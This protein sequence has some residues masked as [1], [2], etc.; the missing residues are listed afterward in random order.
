MYDGGKIII[1]LIIFVVL[2]SI[3][4]WYNA[5]TGSTDYVPDLAKAE[6]QVPQ[7]SERRP[8]LLGL[9]LNAGEY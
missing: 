6:G 9:S 1:G 3:P 5:A 8:L 7:L 2:V 4:V